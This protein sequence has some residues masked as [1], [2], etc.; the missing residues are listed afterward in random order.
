MH[1]KS[2]IESYELILQAKK[3][4]TFQDK[5]ICVADR[6]LH[7]CE[8]LSMEYNLDSKDLTDKEKYLIKLTDQLYKIIHSINKYNCCYDAHDRW[9]EETEKHFQELFKEYTDEDLDKERL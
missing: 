2:L 9:R 6:L 1:A 4:G 8:D 5:A 7:E 3:E